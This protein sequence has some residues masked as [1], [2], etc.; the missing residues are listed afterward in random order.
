MTPWNPPP[1]D[2]TSLLFLFLNIRNHQAP[3]LVT[4]YAPSRR[5]LPGSLVPPSLLRR[6]NIYTESVPR[7]RPNHSICRYQTMLDW[8]IPLRAYLIM[9]GC[10]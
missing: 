6:R 7:R 2:G 3:N 8:Y 4:V 9:K 5:L 10:G 1:I